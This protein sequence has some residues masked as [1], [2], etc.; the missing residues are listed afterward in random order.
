[1]P[2]S[3]GPGSPGSLSDSML[4]GGQSPLGFPVCH[5]HSPTTGLFK[6]LEVK[7]L[8][9]KV[10]VQSPLPHLT[11]LWTFLALPLEGSLCIFPLRVLKAALAYL[12]VWT[13]VSGVG[14]ALTGDELFS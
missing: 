14:A 1:M 4:A 2:G 6:G 11:L 9:K 5:K 7:L 3:T 10:T 12:L 13:N 8:K